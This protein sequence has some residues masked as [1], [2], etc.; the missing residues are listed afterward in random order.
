MHLLMHE[1][2][3]LPLANDC[4][5]QLTGAGLRRDHVHRASLASS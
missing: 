1:T 5:F 4:F 3:L 2:V